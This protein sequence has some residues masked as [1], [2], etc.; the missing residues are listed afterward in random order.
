M[1]SMGGEGPAKAGAHEEQAETGED[2]RRRATEQRGPG[3]AGISTS[4]GH[5]V[6]HLPVLPAGSFLVCA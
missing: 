3:S 2:Q 4:S 6:V 5:W 1:R